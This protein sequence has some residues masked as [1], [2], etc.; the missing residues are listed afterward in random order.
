MP[1]AGEEHPEF[2]RF[3]RV[4]KEKWPSAADMPQDFR[5]A[6]RM[7]SLPLMKYTNIL[8]HNTRAT[9]LFIACLINLPYLYPLFEI[10]VLAAIYYY[11]KYRHETMCKGFKNI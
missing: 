4:V 1:Q 9:V 3:F 10:T 7:K 5:Q 6:F 2:Q 11:M 8:T